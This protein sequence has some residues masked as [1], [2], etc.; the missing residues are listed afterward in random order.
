[1]GYG[2][3]SGATT[4][5]NQAIVVIG[6]G[7]N[8]DAFSRLRASNPDTVFDSTFQYDLQP[9][10]F[11][12]STANGGSVVHNAA[13][14]SARLALDGTDSGEAILQSKQYHR[15]IPGKSQLIIMTGWLNTAK[16]GVTKR[17]GYFD[18]SNGIYFEQNGTSGLRLV[19]RSKVS[20]SVVNEEV[21]QA[22]WNL[23]TLLGTAGSANPSGITLDPMAV[24]I[25][26]IDLQWLGMG[27]VRVGFDIG[28][29]IVYV[30]EFLHA[31]VLASVYMQT[32]NLPVRWELAG[33]LVAGM[34][35]TCSAV[36]SEGGADK[37]LGYQFSYDRAS[38]TAAS[39]AQTYAF[40]VRPKATF[41][42][43]TNRMLLRP[44]AFGCLV[45]GN[46]PVLV[47]IYYGTTI[48]GSPSWTDI[49][50]N[51]SGLQVDTAGTPSGGVKA[52][53][54]FVASSNQS[55]TATG[56]TFSARYPLAL[57]IAGTGYNHFTVYVT[58]IGGDSACRPS[59]QWEEVR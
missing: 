20:G 36:I 7:A 53:S 10:M 56:R 30:H 23:D 29:K 32:A 6:D 26:I 11:E 48:G 45:T 24:Y 3:E 19:R 34:D 9:L 47:E 31:N 21:E 59:I 44:T 27:R 12:Q 25:L 51:Y 50:T 38:V 13:R 46:S 39:G 16:E 14:V 55:K 54:F 52:D 40:S 15:Y 22:D 43:I 2:L 28:G 41:N 35:A 1:M 49:D 4:A 37:F 8:L 57:D 5:D 17:V 58:G 42:S 33:S 18:A